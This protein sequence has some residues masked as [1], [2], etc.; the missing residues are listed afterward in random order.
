[1]NPPKVHTFYRI[2]YKNPGSIQIHPFPVGAEELDRT[3][4][5]M[6]TM[7]QWEG[8]EFTVTQVITINQEIKKFK[9]V[10]L[11]EL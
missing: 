1:M 5:E 11:S 10:P 2:E 6:Q 4:E 8:C 3:I 9:N 7:K